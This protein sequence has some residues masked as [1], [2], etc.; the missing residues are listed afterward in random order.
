MIMLRSIVQL[1]SRQ[2]KN[3]QRENINVKWTFVGRRHFFL[4]WQHTAGKVILC[5]DNFHLIAVM[6]IIIIINFRRLRCFMQNETRQCE[7]IKVILFNRGAP[8]KQ[9]F[10]LL[11][12]QLSRGKMIMKYVLQIVRIK[13]KKLGKSYE[14]N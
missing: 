1:L 13:V 3:E 11:V 9:G 14:L 12:F 6:M 4:L 8:F 5:A 10:L 7:K 2:K